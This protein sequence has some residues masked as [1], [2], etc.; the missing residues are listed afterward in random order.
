MAAGGAERLPRY[1]TARE[2]AEAGRPLLSALGRVYDLGPLL[3]ERRGTGVA[4]V[5]TGP[6]P[7]PG[8][9]PEALSPTLPPR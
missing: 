1:L 9:G 7:G 2:V 6:S 3:R 5:G 8:P 4:A